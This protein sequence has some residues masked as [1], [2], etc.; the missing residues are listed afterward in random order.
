MQRR[1][2]RT[3]RVILTAAAETF[4][5]RGYLGTSLQNIVTGRQ[6]SK[7][8]LYFHFQSKEDLALAILSAQQEVWPSLISELRLRET[9][10]IRLLLELFRQATTA[11]R[12]DALARAGSRLAC[13]LDLIGPS[14]P[15]LFASWADVV[16]ELLHEAHQQGDLLSDA[17]SRGVAE[18]LV[19]SFTGLQR[20]TAICAGRDLHEHVTTMWRHLLP[21]LVPAERLPAIMDHLAA[22]RA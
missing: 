16:E 8:A 17:N 6:V 13:E 1:A 11:L 21:G 5:A 2:E 3:R 20:M 15:R 22:Q 10:A 18:F 4:E 12:H 14:A 9:S 19:A 7:G